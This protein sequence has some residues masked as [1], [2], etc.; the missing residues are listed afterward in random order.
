MLVAI[1]AQYAGCADA[2][3]IANA[4]PIIANEAP[5]NEIC[6]TWDECNAIIQAGG[7]PNYDGATGPLD[8][9]EYGDPKA[10]TIAIVEY[11]SNTEFEEIGQVTAEVPTP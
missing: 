3:A 9:N 8:F 7:T 1:A 11:I 4:L 10:A 2:R 5:G 6:K